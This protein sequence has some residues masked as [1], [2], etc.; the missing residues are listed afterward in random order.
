MSVPRL[1]HTNTD[2][3]EPVSILLSFTNVIPKYGTNTLKHKSQPNAESHHS[4][5]FQWKIFIHIVK[6]FFF[7]LY[8][9]CILLI[10]RAHDFFFF[11]KPLKFVICR[12]RIRSRINVYLWSIL[13]QRKNVLHYTKMTPDDNDYTQQDAI[14]LYV[15]AQCAHLHLEESWAR[16]KIAV[17]NQ[18]FTSN[19]I[20]IRF[21]NNIIQYY[22]TQCDQTYFVDFAHSLI[23]LILMQK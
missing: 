22:F 8:F 16:K 23:N 10:L 21:H 18:S 20:I 9:S 14:T 11:N 3:Y 15:L 12:R 2:R 7:F 6:N 19:M 5:F 13:I 1:V 4:I 17:A